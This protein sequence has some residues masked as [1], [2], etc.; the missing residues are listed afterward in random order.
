M[1]LTPTADEKKKKPAARK[2]AASTGGKKKT[3]AQLLEE[4][5][6]D[7]AKKAIEAVNKATKSL[8][9]NEELLDSEQ[10]T[11]IAVVEAGGWQGGGGADKM[12]ENHGNVEYP[13]GHPDCL[14]KVTIVISGIL[15]SMM[16]DE[17]TE[18]IK[19]HGGRVTSGVT[20][21]T[22]FLLCGKIS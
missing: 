2:S 5:L 21:N 22:T 4:S 19:R 18:Y 16:R 10:I 14:A 9:S 13:R 6:S 15:D 17:A 3:A 11:K 7:S 8:P 1:Q 12:P 20:G